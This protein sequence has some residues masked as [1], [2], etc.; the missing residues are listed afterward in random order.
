[1][2]NTAIKLFPLLLRICKIMLIPPSNNNNNKRNNNNNKNNNNKNNKINLKHKRISHFYTIKKNKKSLTQSTEEILDS[3]NGNMINN[4][5]KP[6]WRFYGCV[7]KYLFFLPA[8][9]K[10]TT[11]T[12]TTTTTTKT[13]TIKAICEQ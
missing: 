4:T 11:T 8:T 10:A 12:T 1:M 5:T 7:K 9:A 2:F 13:S 3:F 6:N